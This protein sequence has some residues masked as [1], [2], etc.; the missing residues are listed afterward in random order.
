MAT[1]ARMPAKIIAISTGS[2]VTSLSSAQEGVCGVIPPEFLT[3]Q[4]SRRSSWTCR[5][6]QHA[7][8]AS[9]VAA[10]VRRAQM[11]AAPDH[12]A[13]DFDVGKIGIGARVVPAAARIFR[14]AGRLLH[15]GFGVRTGAASA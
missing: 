13:R 7:R 14:D 1:T 10:I 9:M 8:G 6:A 4:R 3:T 12:L 2:V 5:W 15:I 11:R